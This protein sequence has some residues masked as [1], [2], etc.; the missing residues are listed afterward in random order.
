MK[1]FPL[2]ARCCIKDLDNIFS[3]DIS[4]INHVLIIYEIEIH[5]T[6]EQHRC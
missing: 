3:L 6:F 4:V 5:L 2:C 1:E